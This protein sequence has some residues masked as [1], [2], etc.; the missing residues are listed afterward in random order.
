MITIS[1]II[2][3][4]TIPIPQPDQVRIYIAEP[5][6]KAAMKYHGILF[7][8][9]N[10]EGILRFKRKGRICKLF[11]GAFERKWKSKKQKLLTKGEVQ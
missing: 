11:T 10:E 7:A 1:L 3:L 2:W 6:V 5:K 4:L 8:E 9:S